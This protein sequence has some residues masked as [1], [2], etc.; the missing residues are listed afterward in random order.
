MSDQ[1][2][3]NKS[4][5]S[6]SDMKIDNNSSEDNEIGDNCSNVSGSKKPKAKRN[7]QTLDLPCIPRKNQIVTKK[8]YHK[9]TD[10]QKAM[11]EHP[12]SWSF[13]VSLQDVKAVTYHYGIRVDAPIGAKRAVK[14]SL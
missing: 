7:K 8:W 1:L 4:N 2:G 6:N 3:E 9:L 11:E 5:S 10:K 13:E 14:V 12:N